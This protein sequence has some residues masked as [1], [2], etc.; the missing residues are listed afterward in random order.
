[1][2]LADVCWDGVAGLDYHNLVLACYIM[3]IARLA[4]ARALVNAKKKT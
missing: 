4:L 3:G 1:M 2:H